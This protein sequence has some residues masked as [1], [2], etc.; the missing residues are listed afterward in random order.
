EGRPVG[1]RSRAGFTLIELLVVIA[2]ISIL[3]AL[4]LPAVQQAREAARRVGCKNNLMQI[5]MALQNF[6]QAHERLPSGCINPDGPIRNEPEGQHVSWIVELLPFLEQ[7]NA[8]N[9]FDISAG[10]YAKKNAEVAAMPI[11]V[12]QC[13][14]DSYSD[15]SRTLADNHIALTNYAGC[16]HD[17]ESPI[18]EDNHGVM[19]LNSR[20]SYVDIPD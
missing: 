5:G 15:R 16:H 2:I 1:R 8:A 10:A 4:L 6:D 3:I 18:A 11:A 12:L 19:F 13:P 20:I 17:V 9:K 14:S 7:Q